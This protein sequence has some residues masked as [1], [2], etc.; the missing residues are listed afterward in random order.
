MNAVQNFGRSNTNSNR[1]AF[2]LTELLVVIAT[3]GILAAVVLPTLAGTKTD[4]KSFQ[5]LN[6]LKQ[7]ATAW[8]LYSDESNDRLVNLSTYQSSPSGSQITANAPQGV[9]WRTQSA[10]VQ[11]PLPAGVSPFT[12]AAQKYRIEMG[13]KQPNT[14]IVGPLYGFAPNADIV[15]CPA[16][17]RANL[18]VRIQPYGGPFA[19]DSYSGSG[20]LN[21]ESVGDPRMI[22]KRTGITRPAD[23]FVWAEAADTRGENLGSWWL[24]TYGTPNDS[25]GPF[26]AAKFADSPAPFHPAAANF[27]FCDGHVESHKW[28]NAATIAF[29][30]ATSANKDDGSAALTAANQ[31][32]NVD[33]IWV[34][35]HY[36][37]PQNP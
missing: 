28:Q 12:P 29:A 14:T 17:W 8:I 16:D 25:G 13:Y 31:P 33:L 35:S 4:S 32:G 11:Q 5:C 37:G 19:W 21:G 24:G 2:T 10:L 1:K 7:L 36:A 3:M 34:A 23:K 18:P 30:N 26:H 9:P 22:L 15:H 20:F 27:N 6:N